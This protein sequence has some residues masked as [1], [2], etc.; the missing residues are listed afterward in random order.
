VT[1][2]RL[3]YLDFKRFNNYGC[4]NNI[5]EPEGPVPRVCTTCFFGTTPLGG[6]MLCKNILLTIINM[7]FW[8]SNKPSLNSGCVQILLF[9]IAAS[10]GPCFVKTFFNTAGRE[11]LK[12]ERLK[13]KTV[14]SA[15]MSAKITLPSLKAQF[16]K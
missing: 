15:L 13:G 8:Q 3:K 14:I 11:R 9:G 6:A 5:A 12:A 4:K 7:L 1:N 10:G 16:R 2:P